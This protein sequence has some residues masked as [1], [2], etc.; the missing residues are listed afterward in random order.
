MKDQFT[1]TWDQAL[2]PLRTE[3]SQL[4]TEIHK[5]ALPSHHPAGYHFWYTCSYI[6]AI[7]QLRSFYCGQPVCATPG[8]CGK[9]YFKATAKP[10]QSVNGVNF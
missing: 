2:S 4:R 5:T 3:N 6:P 7:Q 8:K 1:I 9:A 10:R